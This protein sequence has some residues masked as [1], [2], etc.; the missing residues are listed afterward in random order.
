VLDRALFGNLDNLDVNVDDP[1][2]KYVPPNGLLLTVNLGQWYNSAYR[3]E[4]KDPSKDFMMPIIFACNETH[5]RK[6]GKASSWP[7]LFTTSI[8]NQKTRNLPIV[9]RTLLGYINDLSLLQSTAEDTNLSQEVKAERLNAI[10]KTILATVIEA[11]QS[12]ALGN[13]P[14]IFGDDIKLVNLKVPV[15]FI[16]GDMQGGDMI[17]CTTGHYSN[18]LHRLC[19]KC[20]VRGDESGDP[21]VQC[22]KINMVRIMQLVKDIRQDILDDFNKYNVDNA[23][24]DVSYGGCLFGIFSAS[25]PIEP[26]HVLEN[27]IIPNCLTILFK[28]E[29]CPA[30]KGELDSLVRHLTFYPR[31]RF[32]SS[33]SGP[34][35]PRL[36][37]KDGIP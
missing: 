4:V 6:G 12:G 10:F 2:G 28:D 7:L 32:A 29:I 17:C 20:N 37:W 30:L 21:L 13:I 18:K 24:F 31:Q 23:W 19:R 15:I 26:L 14:F 9:W 8:L 16:I 22:K 5:L 36:L 35:M 27:G 25:C 1:Y 11:Q 3:H 34:C 33:G